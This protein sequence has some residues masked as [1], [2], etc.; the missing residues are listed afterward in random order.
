MA[1]A[2]ITGASSGIGREFAFKLRDMAGIDEFWL[3]A[4]NVERLNKVGDELGVK[5]KVISADLTKSEEI[6]KISR[7]TPF[8]KA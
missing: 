1:V 6:E 4:R 2:V 7:G 8:G 3:I 5:Y